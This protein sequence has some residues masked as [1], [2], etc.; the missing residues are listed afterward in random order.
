MGA[1]PTSET[2]A[3]SLAIPYP[4]I[5][6]DLPS[7][8]GRYEIVRVLGR[9]GMGA[10]Y[11]ARDSQLDRL[12]ALKVPHREVAQNPEVR[13]RFLREA[14]AA[15]KFHHPNFC[16]IF[17]I[18]EV[19]G[20]PYL[21][22]A[23]IEGG[24]LASKIKRGQ[25]WEPRKAAKVIRQLAVALAEAHRQGI[26]H[27][28]LKPANVMIDA[29]GGLVLM[30]FGLARQFE[31][32][33]ATLTAAGAI[34]GTPSYMPPEQAEGNIKAIG[35]R[36]DLYSLGVILYELLA[37]L[38]PF[39][40]PV[41]KVLGMIVFVEPTP[42]SA[43]RS[44]L[45]PRLEAICLKAMEKK[46]DNRHASM[47]EFAAALTRF[48]AEEAVPSPVVPHKKDEQVGVIEPA[49][50]PP[51]KAERA[52]DASR[53][54]PVKPRI[55]LIA[56]PPKQAERVPDAPKPAPVKARIEPVA[57]PLNKVTKDIFDDIDFSLEIED[58]D[59]LSL[60]DEPE[61]A[62]VK[63]RVEPVAPSRK[64][65][66]PDFITTKTA[67]IPL[68]L[69]PAGT[70]LM[71]SPKGVGQNDERPQHKVTIRQPFYLAICPVTQ[72]Q[73][74]KLMGKN[75]SHFAATGD[76]KDKVARMDTSRFPVESVSWFESVQF[77]NALSQAEGLKPYYKVQGEQV[78]IAGGDGFRLPTEA[79]WEYACRA[80]TLL[81]YGFRGGEQELSGYGWYNKNSDG[82]TH[83]VGE[84]RANWN[85]LHDMH[86]NVW[87]WVWDSYEADY[88]LRS[89][90]ADPLGP[91]QTAG[92]VYRGGCWRSSPRD[93]RSAFR[94]RGN[95]GSRYYDLGFRVARA[96]SDF[97]NKRS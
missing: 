90:T 96:R 13:E 43:H 3:D 55:E 67:D 40:G 66:V 94:F 21:T 91:S 53:P 42:P 88:Y 7:P 12:V 25:P 83:A 47:D 33:D 32:D 48:L 41:T 75:P 52:R 69:I 31:S 6:V 77:C 60:E 23:Y 8:F 10:V 97:M 4:P 80:G 84:A 44:G 58:I 68:K 29:R 89:P 61:P 18:G 49:A 82:R 34:L 5:E 51:K 9:G 35:P 14:R 17:D 71:G 22:M 11:L 62:V 46:P 50:P 36:S 86:G 45:D 63:A 73:Y 72:R 79:E 26:V 28:D 1:A 59:D 24:T 27:R 95:P 54:P 39:E 81:P 65:A 56:P 15:A 76:G 2:D 16:P 64:K 74:A 93:C 37:G 30:D 78:E 57:P 70:F 87:E 92:R 85:G 38:R 19:D 20:I